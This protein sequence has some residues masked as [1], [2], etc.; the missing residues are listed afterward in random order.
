MR[1]PAPVTD[2]ACVAALSA[3]ALACVAAMSV[4]RWLTRVAPL[5]MPFSF[6]AALP[7]AALC[8]A[9]HAAPGHKT[10][11]HADG[12]SRPGPRTPM[13]LT[14]ASIHHMYS[15]TV[16]QPKGTT[17]AMPLVLLAFHMPAAAQ[18]WQVCLCSTSARAQAQL[19]TQPAQHPHRPLQHAAAQQPEKCENLNRILCICRAWCRQVGRQEPH[20]AARCR[21]SSVAAAVPS[22]AA[23]SLCPPSPTSS[24][25]H[26]SASPDASLLHI[27]ASS[28]CDPSLLFLNSCAESEVDAPLRPV[29]EARPADSRAANA[30]LLPLTMSDS[31]SDLCEGRADGF[32]ESASSDAPARGVWLHEWPGSRIHPSAHGIHEEAPP[33]SQH[34]TDQH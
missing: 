15:F 18:V 4:I 24:P 5:S 12:G 8:K 14:Q 2:L 26:S 11:P 13:Q 19:A 30:A 6:V 16:V 17:T 28:S 25:T 23:P 32:R 1:R 34:C 9:L 27:E 3:T 20:R 33:S 10:L 31:D 7:L 21:P 29:P 22:P